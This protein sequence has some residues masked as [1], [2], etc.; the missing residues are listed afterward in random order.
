MKNKNLPLKHNSDLIPTA[1]LLRREMTKE[2]KHLW[3]DF[4]SKYPL[5]FTRQ[6]IIAKYIADFYCAKAKLVI[7]LD[8]GQHR[9]PECREYDGNRTQFFQQYGLV[10][11][12]I[13]NKEIT[14]N[15]D[16]M[17]RYID[18]VIKRRLNGEAMPEFMQQSLP[19]F[20]EGGLPK[21]RR[22]GKM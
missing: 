3:Y 10:V 4:L 21:A 12:R 16:G 6:K 22:K 20:R 7:E 8:G 19:Y 18:S 9:T 15:F 17:C 1:R 11:L 5:R 2:E 13:P 14:Q